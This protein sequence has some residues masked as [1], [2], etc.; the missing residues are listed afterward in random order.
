M[1]FSRKA[2]WRLCQSIWLVPRTKFCMKMMEWTRNSKGSHFVLSQQSKNW[3][4]ILSSELDNKKQDNFFLLNSN[5]KNWNNVLNSYSFNKR[6]YSKRITYC[7]SFLVAKIFGF[8]GY[9]ITKGPQFFLYQ[10][11][12]DLDKKLIAVWWRERL[13]YHDYDT[14]ENNLP[15]HG[16]CHIHFLNCRFQWLTWDFTTSVLLPE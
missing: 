14:M 15:F 1:I 9:Q 4:E 12:Q 8:L 2:T 7:Q 5:S 16:S 3:C 13:H 10:I 6:N 11:T